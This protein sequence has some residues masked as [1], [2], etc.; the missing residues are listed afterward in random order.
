[1]GFGFLCFFYVLPST[2]WAFFV[3]H[4]HGTPDDEPLMYMRSAV[5]N[6]WVAVTISGFTWRK[7]LYPLK[8]ALQSHLKNKFNMDFETNLNIPHAYKKAWYHR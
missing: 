4:P 6:L 1:M 7:A 5:I 3:E 8:R 2:Y